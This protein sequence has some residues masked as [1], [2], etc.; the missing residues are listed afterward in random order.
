MATR[1]CDPRRSEWARPVDNRY[2]AH[3]RPDKYCPIGFRYVEQPGNQQ[4]KFIPVLSENSPRLEEDPITS[5]VMEQKR[6]ADA[7][8]RRVLNESRRDQRASTRFALKSRSQLREASELQLGTLSSSGDDYFRKQ[9]PELIPPPKLAATVARP[10]PPGTVPRGGWSSAKELQLTA[11]VEEMRERAHPPIE[12]GTSPARRSLF[13]RVKGEQWAEEVTLRRFEEDA[14][15]IEWRNQYV[16]SRRALTRERFR[17]RQQ[18]NRALEQRSRDWGSSSLMPALAGQE[19]GTKPPRRRARHQSGSCTQRSSYNA[20]ASRLSAT[21]SAEEEAS[22]QEL[23][24]T[25]AR[26]TDMDELNRTASLAAEQAKR[27]RVVN[28]NRKRFREVN[29]Q[30]A[31][32]PHTAFHSVKSKPWCDWIEHSSTPPPHSLHSNVEP[33]ANDIAGAARFAATIGAI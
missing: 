13:F 25:I 28:V 5:R 9:Q 30:G 32:V 1:R 2:R 14:A 24:Y 21:H 29:R 22:A 27:P 33:L 18:Q 20:S 8:D 31:F 17:R 7:V 15:L 26:A 23:L 10:G 19:D 6:I 11:A 3:T 4:M 12:P 16:R